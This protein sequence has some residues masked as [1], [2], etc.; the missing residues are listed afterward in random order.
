MVLYANTAQNDSLFRK[1]IRGQQQKGWMKNMNKTISRI[2]AGVLA[3]AT[4]LTFAACGTDS[5][6]SS[7]SK[8]SSAAGSTAS[9]SVSSM[10]ASSA[11]GGETS[12]AAAPG[13][14]YAS[15]EEF[16]KSD[17]VQSQMSALQE[18]L[19]S[20]GMKIE[21]SADGD[22]LVYTFAYPEGVPTDNLGDALETALD[23]QA[24]TFEAAAASLKASVDV[25]NPVVVVRYTDSKGKEL[26][27]REFTA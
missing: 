9:S 24:A 25:E 5:G 15:I 27:S 13:Q 22:K 17:E 16:I 10:P 7:A 26:V 11:A 6:S 3:S 18:S 20:S 23:S 1:R 14:K 19:G 12:S 21:L 4:I 8:A 2:L